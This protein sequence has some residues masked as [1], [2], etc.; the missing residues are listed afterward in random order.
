MPAV[1]AN[2]DGLLREVSFCENSVRVVEEGDAEGGF[3]GGGETCDRNEDPGVWRGAMIHGSGNRSELEVFEERGARCT[4]LSG[5]LV[6][7]LGC[8][9][10]S[11]WCEEEVGVGE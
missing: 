9:R 10:R 8:E 2:D 5:L 3:A 11:P 4:L 6:R 7:E 1:L